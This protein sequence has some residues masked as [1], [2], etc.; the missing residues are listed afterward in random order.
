M[1][2]ALLPAAAG[3]NLGGAALGGWAGETATF[4]AQLGGIAALG[5][6]IILLLMVVALG[7]FAY[8]ALRGDGIRWPD[9]EEL[10][11][12]DLGRGD[13]DDEWKYY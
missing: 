2:L 6:S 3:S 13:E 5:G 11:D 8:K 10:D 4:G 7:G 9:E 1:T 12:D